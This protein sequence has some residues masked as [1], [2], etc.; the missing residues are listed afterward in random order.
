MVI[1]EIM[2]A[3]YSAPESK[4]IVE[5]FN[6]VILLF[7]FEIPKKD[8]YVRMSVPLSPGRHKNEII[9]KMAFVLRKCIQI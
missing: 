9:A 3:G 8:R 2:L 4:Y 7:Q 5:Y 6:T 1:E